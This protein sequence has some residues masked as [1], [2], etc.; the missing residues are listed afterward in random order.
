MKNMTQ[1]S[2][3]VFNTIQTQMIFTSSENT[4]RYDLLAFMKNLL[5]T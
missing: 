1:E 4:L 5:D 2:M 3:L